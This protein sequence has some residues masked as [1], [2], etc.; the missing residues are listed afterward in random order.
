MKVTV[1]NPP[2]APQPPKT[3]SI[4]LSETDA[5]LLLAILGGAN[6]KGEDFKPLFHNNHNRYGSV[7]DETFGHRLY[8]HL[9][10]VIQRL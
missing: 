5:R 8:T 1:N 9:K 6:Y 10:P 3:V 2:P 4:E 7:W